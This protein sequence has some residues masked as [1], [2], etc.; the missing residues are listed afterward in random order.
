V[1]GACCLSGHVIIGKVLLLVG[2]QLLG[3]GI[4]ETLGSIR[5]QVVSVYLRLVFVAL[6]H[7]FEMLFH[8]ELAG[9][10]RKIRHLLFV[11]FIYDHSIVIF[12]LVHRVMIICHH[13]RLVE[14]V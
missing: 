9:P 6:N 1:E 12:R 3:L 13:L 2:G 10:P 11:F 5:G 8:R 14:S 4:V 7:L